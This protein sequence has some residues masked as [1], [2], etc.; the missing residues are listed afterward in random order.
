MLEAAGMRVFHQS[1]GAPAPAAEISA[2]GD[3]QSFCGLPYPMELEV[4]SQ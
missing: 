3:F 2:L 4:Q 1:I